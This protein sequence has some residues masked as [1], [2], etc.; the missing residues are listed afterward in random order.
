NYTVNSSK[1]FQAGSLQLDTPID[2]GW[3]DFQLIVTDWIPRARIEREVIDVSQ[4]DNSQSANAVPAVLVESS[5]GDRQWLQWGEPLAVANPS[6]ENPHG[7]LFA[8]YSPK[9]MELPFA[10]ALEDFIVERNEGAESVA[11]WTS[12]IR[13]DDPLLGQHAFRKVWMNHPTWYRG[14]KIAQA[15]WNPGDLRQS[16]LQVKREPAWVTA[17]TWIGSLLVVIGIGV[18][19]YGQELAKQYRRLVSQFRKS[20]SG[21]AVLTDSTLA[22]TADR[23]SVDANDLSPQASS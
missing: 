11:M 15:S 13:I 17:L 20:D 2:L 5:S 19:F 6:V 18:M 23:S 14:W 1:G 21:S 22:P 7:E 9:S 4:T 12:Q 16:T 8:V 3:A 10:V